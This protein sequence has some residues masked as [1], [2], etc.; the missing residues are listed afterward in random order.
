MK[1]FDLKSHLEHIEKKFLIKAIRSYP[2]SHELGA[3]YL[4]LLRTTYI[5]KLKKYGL[6]YKIRKAARPDSNGNT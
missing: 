1:T 6:Y 2:D 5:M 3:K 4:R